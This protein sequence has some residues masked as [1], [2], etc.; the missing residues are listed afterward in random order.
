MMKSADEHRNDWPRRHGRG[1]QILEE[2]IAVWL[3]RGA[4][5]ISIVTTIAIV[6]T[7]VGESVGFFREVPI[8]EFISGKRWAPLFKPQ[9]FGVLP[10]I[11]GTALVAIIAG[12]VALSLGTGSA[13][14]LSEYAPQF[15]R[16]I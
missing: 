4:A 9:D 8:W 7:L 5:L 14:F 10:L 12:A 15:C 6:S 13:I 2:R 16:T 1:R 3:L 11:A